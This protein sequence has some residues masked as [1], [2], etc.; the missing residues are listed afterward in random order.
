MALRRADK[1]DSLSLVSSIDPK[2]GLVDRNDGVPGMEF[3]HANE[4][5]ISHVRL[6]IG[7]APRQLPQS[8]DVFGEVERYLQQTVFDQGQHVGTRAQMECRLA[9]NRF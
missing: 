3:A 6:A 9:K 7:I 5:Q 4:T 8:G 2:I 1:G